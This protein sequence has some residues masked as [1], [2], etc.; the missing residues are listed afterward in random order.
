M[1]RI[2]I[3]DRM[4]S[5]AKKFIKVLFEKYPERKKAIAIPEKCEGQDVE[6]LKKALLT[7]LKKDG[8]IFYLGGSDST[9]TNDLIVSHIDE[10]FQEKIEV[11]LEFDIPNKHQVFVEICKTTETT[12]IQL[13]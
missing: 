7:E 5:L 4:A 10:I 6:N 3:H 12:G 1:Y 9:T 11:P 8:S 2:E 13:F